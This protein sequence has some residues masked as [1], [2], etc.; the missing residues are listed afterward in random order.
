MSDTEVR[1]MGAAR[2]RAEASLELVQEY[3]ARVQVLDGDRVALPHRRMLVG[4]IAAAIRDAEA[5][6]RKGAA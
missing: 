3:Q 5:R 4:M 2:E 6:G 1:A